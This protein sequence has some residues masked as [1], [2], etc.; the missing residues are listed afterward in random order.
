MPRALGKPPYE[1][2]NWQSMNEGQKRYAME[3]WQLARV[4]RGL[5]IDHPH[6]GIQDE[7][8]HLQ[9]PEEH[10]EPDDSEDL[11]PDDVDFEGIEEEP[12]FSEAGS[13]FSVPEIPDVP[14]DEEGDD[15]PP[16]NQEMSSAESMET[17]GPSS[18]KR[19]AQQTP[20]K[21]KVSSSQKTPRRRLPGTAR[22]QG[23]TA[24]MTESVDDNT[25]IARPLGHSGEGYFHYKKVH[26]FVTFGLAYSPIRRT[27][28]VGEQTFNDVY[29]VTPMAEIPWDRLFMY[30]NPSEY[31]I[32]PE[33]AEVMSMSCRVKAENVRIAF[34]TNST[35]SNLATLNQNKF[36]RVGHGLRQ[37][38]QGIN[39][40]P[41]TFQDDQPMITSSLTYQTNH[42]SD[43]DY[44]VNKFYGILNS[45]AGFYEDIPSHQF[46]LPVP[47]QYYYAQVTQKEDKDNTGWPELQM[48]LKEMEADSHAGTNIVNVHYKPKVG[49]LKRSTNVFMTTV[50]RS[51]NDTSAK[52]I[53]GSGNTGV[54]QITLS[55]E[56]NTNRLAFRVENSM[57]VN[58][59]IDQ[60]T[61]EMG[62]VAQLIEKSHLYFRDLK[63]ANDDNRPRTCPSLHVGL[64][65]V[66][67]LTSSVIS[68]DAVQKY[69]D[70]QA[71]YEVTCE[72]TVKV[73][74]PTQRALAPTF[75]VPIDNRMFKVHENV[76]T[77]AEPDKNR[78]MVHG[79]YTYA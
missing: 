59:D 29:M 17:D 12:L 66:I 8:G 57:T 25:V 40:K 69:T 3:Q 79:L 24:A 16:G 50:P 72:C 15:H 23:D 14:S 20:D 7:H 55:T 46:G 34:P 53:E 75:N 71:Y 21:D 4:R 54:R 18:R 44:Y 9:E 51:S 2:N 28:T 41:T 62:N 68:N 60:F 76:Y 22:A 19:P 78:S 45:N 39:V 1:R 11:F 6:P 33:T 56:A 67:A 31:R 5:P 42:N 38:C 13:P 65:P 52:F 63:D 47:I 35:A 73:T 43:Y 64:Q 58:A 37:H 36:L 61:P 77:G 49:I 74:F 48:Y 26:R 10:S 30:M 32:L 27:Y 70:A